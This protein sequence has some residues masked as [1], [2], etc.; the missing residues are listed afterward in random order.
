M[1]FAL[2]GVTGADNTI[3]QARS[4]SDL[5]ARPKNCVLEMNARADLATGADRVKA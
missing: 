5:R 2:G 3:V 1:E 4:G